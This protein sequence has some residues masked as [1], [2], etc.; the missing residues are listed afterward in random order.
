MLLYKTEAGYCRSYSASKKK[1]QN[2]EIGS[3]AK[4]EGMSI[5]YSGENFGK[6]AKKGKSQQVDK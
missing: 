4:S 5:S 1:L 6:Q 3:K 2:V